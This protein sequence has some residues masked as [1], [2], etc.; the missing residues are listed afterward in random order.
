MFSHYRL[1]TLPLNSLLLIALFLKSHFV[2][3]FLRRTFT[4]AFD[5]WHKNN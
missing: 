4:S 3:V 2:Y 5:H 1:K